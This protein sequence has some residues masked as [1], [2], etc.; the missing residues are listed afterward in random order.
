VDD[1]GQ[2]RWLEAVGQP[3]TER[4]QG[5]LLVIRDITERSLRRL[6]EE[7]VAILAHELR[8]PLT[9]LQGY[10]QLLAA[11]PDDAQRLGQMSLEQLERMRQLIADLFDTAR[12]ETGT[13]SFDYE[14]VSLDRLL[15]DTV[16]VAQTLTQGQRI[17]LDATN[18]AVHVRADPRRIQ[19]V[20]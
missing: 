17:D 5:G 1:D 9:A 6:Q 4:E 13:M 2:R 8:T 18:G 10:L 11:K 7:F 15:R 19:Q 12:I 16:S 3:F 14:D 20:I